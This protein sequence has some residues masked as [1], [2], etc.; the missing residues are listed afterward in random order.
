M[1]YRK[2]LNPAFIAQSTLDSWQWLSR[3]SQEILL[4]LRSTEKMNSDLLD[5]A[6]LLDRTRVYLISSTPT[7]IRG[8]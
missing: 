7:V 6:S 2:L 4:P 3:M 5:R 8:K 1:L